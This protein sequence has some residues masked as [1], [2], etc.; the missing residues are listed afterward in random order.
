M[1]L[2]NPNK[3]FLLLQAREEVAAA[4]GEYQAIRQFSGLSPADLT[5]INL[6]AEP[7]PAFD[8]AEYSG[9]IIGGS[10]FN[11][12]DVESE[13]APVQ[14]R[15][16]AELLYLLDRVIAA[17]FPWLGLCYGMGLLGQ[18]LGASVDRQ[19]GEGA[20]TVLVTQTPAGQADPLLA[21]IPQQFLALTGHKEAISQM[22]AQATLLASSET[23]PV[24]MLRLGANAYATQFHPELDEAGLKERLAIYLDKGYCQPDEYDQV[25]AS[26]HNAPIGH[27]HQILHNFAQRYAVPVTAK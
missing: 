23:G 21:G 5:R 20:G 4:E 13:K 16:E 6:L 27:S 17:D 8:L 25:V 1:P 2:T 10:P 14:Q 15:V 24:Q 9:L 18:Y 22:P 3:P 12:S 26:I 11:T 7:M 19:F